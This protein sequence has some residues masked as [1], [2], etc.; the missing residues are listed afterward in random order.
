MIRHALTIE[1]TAS[2]QSED[3][4]DA[5]VDSI[6]RAV[7]LR[8]ADAAYGGRPISLAGGENVLVVLEAT[9]W[10]VSAS[11]ASSVIRGASVALSVEASE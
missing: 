10:S 7:R 4:A 6:V 11:D 5:L 8:L 2:H 3:G 9:R 1:V